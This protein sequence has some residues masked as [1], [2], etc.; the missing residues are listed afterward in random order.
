MYNQQFNQYNMYDNQMYGQNPMMQQPQ[1]GYNPYMNQMPPMQN[2]QMPPKQETGGIV[3]LNPKK[4]KKRR[5]EITHNNLSL[6]NNLYSLLIS[7][8]SIIKF[9][10]LS[11]Q[12]LIKRSLPI[13]IQ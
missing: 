10:S 2:Q 12:F 7:N 8:P 3:G 1:K 4:N 11:S 9:N 5:E 6:V 13:L